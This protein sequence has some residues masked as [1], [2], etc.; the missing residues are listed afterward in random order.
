MMHI[1]LALI[2]FS[3]LNPMIIF[4][5]SENSDLREWTIVNDVVMGGQSRSSF[6]IDTNAN[7]LFKGSVSLEDNGGFCSVR[8]SFSK[9]LVNGFEKI[10]FRVKG[11]GKKYQVRIKASKSDYYSYIACFETTGEWQTVEV[12]LKEMY[13][14]FRGRKLDQPNFSNDSIEEIAFLIGNKRAETFQLQ[15]DKIMLK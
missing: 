6:T 15:I 3:I 11:D 8:R 13:P 12:P 4:D 1:F 14:S 9:T 5:F 2:F 10:A 7:A